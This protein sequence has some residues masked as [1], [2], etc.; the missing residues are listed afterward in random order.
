[1]NSDLYEL[2]DMVK[3]IKLE[4]TDF[5][6]KGNKSAGTRARKNLSELA[7]WCT[8]KRKDIQEAKNNPEPTV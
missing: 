4:Y 2:D 8:Q 6:E 1:M 5:T 7:K 3:L